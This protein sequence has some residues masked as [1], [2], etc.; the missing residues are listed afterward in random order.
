MRTNQIKIK[1]QSYMN[2]FNHL[3]FTFKLSKRTFN[4]TYAIKHIKS[5]YSFENQTMIL[6]TNMYFHF[7]SEQ[8][9]VTAKK[10]VYFTNFDRPFQTFTGVQF[11]PKNYLVTT[12]T[13]WMSSEFIVKIGKSY[14]RLFCVKHKIV[15]DCSYDVVSIIW[16]H[17]FP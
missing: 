14:L 16:R 11:S 2:T 17:I 5:F 1:S 6:I 13:K 3:I 8:H 15:N 4:K 9:W 10:Y 12:C 7:E